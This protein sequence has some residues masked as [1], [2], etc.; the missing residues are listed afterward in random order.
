MP[1]V[2]LSAEEKARRKAMRDEKKAIG[3]VPSQKQIDNQIQKAKLQLLKMEEKQRVRIA[4]QELLQQKKALKEA[5]SQAKNSKKYSV[6][7]KRSMKQEMKQAKVNMRP[8]EKSVMKSTFVGPLLPT[9]SRRLSKEQRDENYYARRNATRA[10]QG[11]PPLVR[12]GQFPIVQ[13]PEPIVPPAPVR[14]GRGRPRNNP[15]L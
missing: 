13:E 12:V 2:R 7:V 14:R 3:K 1:Y 4:K 15:V 11:L 8:A 10:R 9:Q 6:A 5:K